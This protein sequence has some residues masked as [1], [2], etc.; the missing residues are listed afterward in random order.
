MDLTPYL[1]GKGEDKYFT[2]IINAFRK[3]EGTFVV[4]VQFQ[5]SVLVGKKDDIEKM[6]GL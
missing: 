1:E 5:T 3:P 4:P 6:D 2:N